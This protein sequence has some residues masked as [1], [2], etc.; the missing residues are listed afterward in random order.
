MRSSYSGRA[1]YYERFAFVL[2]VAEVAE[3]AN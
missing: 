1:Y 2:Q 3:G